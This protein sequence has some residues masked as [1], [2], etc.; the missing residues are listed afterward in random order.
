MLFLQMHAQEAEQRAE[1]VEAA[2]QQGNLQQEQKTQPSALKLY[3]TSALT[4]ILSFVVVSGTL[5]NL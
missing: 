1:A 5:C 4:A 2:V 3:G